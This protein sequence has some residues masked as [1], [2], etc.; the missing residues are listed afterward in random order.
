MIITE[1]FHCQGNI[2]IDSL[3]RK[4]YDSDFDR[5]GHTVSPLVTLY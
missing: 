4:W 1:L 5:D 3:M 2:L